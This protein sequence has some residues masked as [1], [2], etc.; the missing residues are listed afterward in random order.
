MIVLTDEVRNN[1]GKF[2]HDYKPMVDKNR[3]SGGFAKKKQPESMLDN[4]TLYTVLGE[5]NTIQ[6]PMVIDS[7]LT[8]PIQEESTSSGLSSF[9]QGMSHGS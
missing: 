8:E 5:T 3:S 4:T 9:H 7:T 1:K 2:I 6:D